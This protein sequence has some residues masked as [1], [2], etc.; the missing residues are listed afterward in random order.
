MVE[1]Y[2]IGAESFADL[3][4][5]SK[6]AAVGTVDDVVI[7]GFIVRDSSSRNQSQSILTRGIGPSLSAKGITNALQDPTLE[8]FDAQG[9]SLALN[10][11]WRS[12]PQAAAIAATG[13]APTNDKESAILATLAPGLYTAILRGSGGTTGTGLVEIYNLGNQ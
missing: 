10:D 7:G 6:R 8:L 2:D 1:I 3:G 9:T 4:N 12:S 13:I 11:D 5:I